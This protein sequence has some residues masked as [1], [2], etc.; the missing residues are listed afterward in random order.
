MDFFPQDV[1][2]FVSCF[3]FIVPSS[4]QDDFGVQLYSAGRGHWLCIFNLRTWQGSLLLPPA[5]C[6]G[7]WGL[8]A[9]LSHCENVAKSFGDTGVA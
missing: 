5:F 1:L 6:L 8:G 3:A 4:S 7:L 9:H 2:G